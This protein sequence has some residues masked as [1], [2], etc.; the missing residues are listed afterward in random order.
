MKIIGPWSILA[1]LFL[2]T[3]VNVGAQSEK[4]MPRIGHLLQN[5]A[6]SRGN[7][8]L[9][10]AF[11]QGLRELG[12]VEG[13]NIAI[14]V[15]SAESKIERLPE[16][17]AEL[18]RLKVDVLLAGGEPPIQAAKE[19]TSTIPIVMTQGPDPIATGLIASLAQPGGN[20]TGLTATLPGLHGKRL[21]LLKES[22]PSVTHMA[23]LW[24]PSNSGAQSGKKEL[25]SVAQSLG[26]KLQA[27]E[28]AKIQRWDEE[29]S[30]LKRQGVGAVLL[31]SLNFATDLRARISEFTLKNRLPVMWVNC[32]IPESGDLMCY[33]PNIADLYRRAATFVDKILKGTTPADLP[34]EQPRKFD[35][36][37]NLKTA[38]Q[39]GVT[40]SPNVL[41]RADRVIR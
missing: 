26:V 16:L 9:R 20:I 41:A 37:I 21:E 17:A 8:A 23:L 19:A 12:Y 6:S 33:S 4:K 15:R 2:A 34:V 28:I 10:E 27:V 22:F 29:F 31:L 7:A 38:K 1:A 5:S 14:E 13:K 36:V 30:S 39:I 11:R 24:D 3:A 40:I 18:V 35:F 32:Q 25:D